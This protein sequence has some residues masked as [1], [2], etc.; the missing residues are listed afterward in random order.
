MIIE[1]IQYWLCTEVIL[2]QSMIT[3]FHYSC[4]FCSTRAY[5]EEGSSTVTRGKKCYSVFTCSDC[6]STVV[7]SVVGPRMHSL[8]GHVAFIFLPAVPVTGWRRRDVD[9]N[10]D[11]DVDGVHDAWTQCLEYNI[12]Q[13]FSVADNDENVEIKLRDGTTMKK[14]MVR[15]EE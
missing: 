2:Q 3:S 6:D 8:D 7:L 10:V 1:N 14:Y 12:Q 11:E 9:T 5:A 13:V 4:T 15:N